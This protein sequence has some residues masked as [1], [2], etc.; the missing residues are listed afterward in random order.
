MAFPTTYEDFIDGIEAVAITGVNRTY[1]GP[2]SGTPSTADCPCKFCIYPGGSER[3]LV[4]G[5]QGGRRSLRVEFWIVVEPVA[6]NIGEEN[7]K[8][9]VKMM[10]TASVAFQN[11][12][13]I[14]SAHLE[15]EIDLVEKDISGVRFWTVVMIIRG[16]G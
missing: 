16:N 5:M 3:S 9:G 15:W 12:A 7:W 6:Q 13:C 4:F 14:T 8:A 10:D 2:P 1:Q 11:A